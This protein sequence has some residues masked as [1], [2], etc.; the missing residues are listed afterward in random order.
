MAKNEDALN[1]ILTSPESAKSGPSAEIELDKDEKEAQE[2]LTREDILSLVFNN[3]TKADKYKKD[4]LD[5]ASKQPKSVQV[6]TPAGWL[7]VDE[8]A[9]M[10]FDPKT[11]DFTKEQK[12][13]KRDLPPQV[14]NLT[15]EQQAELEAMMSQGGNMHGAPPPGMMPQGG[16]PQEGAPMPEGE[17]MPVP[18]GEGQTIQ[19]PEEDPLGGLM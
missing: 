1:D 3:Q 8:A 10:G 2:K 12:G 19:N 7:S 18:E 11:G 17:G 16:A 6:K 15:P 14:A 5:K 4:L 13:Q 9:K